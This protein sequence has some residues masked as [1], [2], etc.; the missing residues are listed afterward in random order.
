MPRK[1][2]VPV[3]FSPGAMKALDY[4]TALTGHLP[5][6]EI[7]L[8]HAIEPMV[9]P[10]KPPRGAGPPSHAAWK[11]KIEERLQAVGRKT[12]SAAKVKVRTLVRTGRAYQEIARAAQAAGADLVVL[13][14]AGY[15][16]NDHSQFGTT[17]E[18]VARNVPCPVLLVRDKNYG[19]KRT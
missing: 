6:A 1:I 10:Q 8:M 4:A 13:G 14:S 5:G 17:A 19:S 12:K 7:I 9:F 15:T 18:R 3:D 11:Q 16:A 2:L